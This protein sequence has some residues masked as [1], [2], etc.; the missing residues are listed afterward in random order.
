MKPYD[1]R[2]S[3]I[4][5]S[6]FG[7][8]SRAQALSAGATARMIER[9][10]EDGRWQLVH[11][12]V[13]ATAGSHPSWQRGQM[14]ASLW[15]K[16]AAGVRAAAYLHRLPSFEAG[17]VEVVTTRN[18][19][20]MPRCGIICHHTTWLP[21][22]QI[23]R[24]QGIPTTSIE[25]TLLDLCGH[26]SKRRSAIAIDQALHGGLTTLGGLDH[27]LFLTA[28]RGRAGCKILR[29][30]VH[31]RAGLREF[32]NSAL[33][34]VVFEMLAVSD[35]PPP[36]LQPVIRG[37]QGF[38]A[39]PDFLWPAEK[40]IVE[41]H[42]KLW[43]QG[44]CAQASDRARHENLASLGYRILYITWADAT[45]YQEA[46]RALISRHLRERSHGPAAEPTS[47][48]HHGRWAS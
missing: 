30:F 15:S 19:R 45:E 8:F 27:C 40:L 5:A 10:L 26:I 44:A 6:Q 28:R 46:T 29:T 47:K 16:G 2:I 31:E 7:V 43:H 12:A 11:P 32:P 20:P 22:S 35:L 34:S 18:K 41:G 36:Q 42:S 39:R 38:I 33:E 48:D 4:A 23:V 13:Y 1:Q 37:P 9:R 25:R 21:P 17:P 24:V 3:L 14:A